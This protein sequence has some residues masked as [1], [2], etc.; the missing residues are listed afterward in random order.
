LDE[1]RAALAEQAHDRAGLVRLGLPE[2][3]C[4]YV[5]PPVLVELVTR[6]PRIDVRVTSGHSAATLG[7]LNAGELDLALLP[8]P[9]DP[10]RLRVTEIGRDELVAIVP[11]EHAWAALPWIGAQDFAER[12]IVVYDRTSQITDLTLGFL[13]GEGVFPR[14]AVEIDHIEAIKELVRAG[15][16]AA[17]VPA[18]SA[19]REL[20]AGTLRA[21]RLGPRGLTRTWGVL[22]RGDRRMPASLRAFVQLLADLLPPLFAVDTGGGSPEPAERLA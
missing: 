22:H 7:R 6:F 15:V 12:P 4:N 8:L 2:P 19:R 1:L 14:I 21:A 20:A 3:P 10:G 11:P 17:V 18:W 5:L 9:V 16:G 13:L